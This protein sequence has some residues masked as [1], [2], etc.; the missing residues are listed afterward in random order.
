MRKDRYL[1]GGGW[2]MGIGKK[3]V[4]QNQRKS[5]RK[6]LFS[7]MFAENQLSPPL[8]FFLKNH[9]KVSPKMWKVRCK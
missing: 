1:V 3:F 9:N 2:G 7:Q 6:K 5:A 4:S 8:Y